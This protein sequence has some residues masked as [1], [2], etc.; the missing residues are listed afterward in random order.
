M[1]RIFSVSFV[2][3]LFIMFSNCSSFNNA[4]LINDNYV[5]SLP[6]SINIE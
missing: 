2:F 3:S 6:R 5:P 4:D 1:K